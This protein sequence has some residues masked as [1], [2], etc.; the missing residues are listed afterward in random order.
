MPDFSCWYL[1]W[2]RKKPDSGN[3]C[4]AFECFFVVQGRRLVLSTE[5]NVDHA[6]HGLS[7][8]YQMPPLSV[9]FADAPRLAPYYEGEP[10]EI[11]ELETVVWDS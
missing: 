1:V 10:D 9:D 3:R 4:V 6:L 8:P 7:L 5:D 11:G 2:L